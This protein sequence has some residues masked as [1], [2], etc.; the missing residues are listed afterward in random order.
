MKKRRLRSPDIAD[1]VVM[2]MA[3]DAA[4]VT[5]GVSDDGGL[6]KQPKRGLPVVALFPVEAVSADGDLQRRR[7]VGISNSLILMRVQHQDISVTRTVSRSALF[8][9]C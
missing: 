6:N 4:T 2:T 8:C 5:Y 9:N 1:A 3:A 7:R